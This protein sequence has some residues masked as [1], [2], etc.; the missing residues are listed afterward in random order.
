MC[1]LS[2]LPSTQPILMGV[3]VRE[4]VSVRLWEGKVAGIVTEKR[5][6]VR[7]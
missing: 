4:R 5:A 7:P 2:R 6:A 3:C 1:S